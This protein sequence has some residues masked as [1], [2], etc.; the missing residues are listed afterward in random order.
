[1]EGDNCGEAY[2]AIVWS[3]LL[4]RESYKLAGAETVENVEGNMLRTAMRGVT[5]LPWSKT[6]LRAKGAR[7]NLGDLLLPATAVAVPGRVGKARSRS[8]SGKQEESDGSILPMKRS[9]KAVM[10]GGGGRGGKG[11]GREKWSAL[12]QALDTEPDTACYKRRR[13]ADRH[14]TGHPGPERRSRPTL[15]RSPVRESRTPG[16]ARGAGGNS[17][18]Y[19]DQ[20]SGRYPAFGAVYGGAAERPNA[21]SIAQGHSP[22]LSGDS[23]FAHHCTVHFG[24]WPGGGGRYLIAARITPTAAT[25]AVPNQIFRSRLSNSSSAT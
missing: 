10:N 24:Q 15:D 1:V 3:G 14:W 6:P 13:P 22:A 20:R 18:P 17:C 16:S 23:Y 8:R 7:R 4:S 12:K 19:R 9:N 25:M 21:L 11:P 2:T 5:T